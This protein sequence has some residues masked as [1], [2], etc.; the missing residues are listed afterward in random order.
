VS[1]FLCGKYRPDI[2]FQ[3]PMHRVIVEVDEDQ[4]KRYDNTC[5]EKRMI[6][7][8]VD[9]ETSPCI[10]LRF[11]PDVWKMNDKV[12]KVSFEKRCEVLLKR[13]KY[14]LD[15]ENVKILNCIMHV[16]KM[17]YDGIELII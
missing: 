14:W 11:N 17:Y 10:F 16:E 3:L 15:Y 7:I 6:S 13:I 1:G 8:T 2:L 12:K 5:E 4:H 9:V